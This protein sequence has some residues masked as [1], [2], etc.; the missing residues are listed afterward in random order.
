MQGQCISHWGCLLDYCVL[1]EIYFIQ[2][3]QIIDIVYDRVT[4]PFMKISEGSTITFD[5]YT[6]K[7]FWTFSKTSK[8][9]PFPMN[10]RVTQIDN[11]THRLT[12]FDVRLDNQGEYTCHGIDEES[13]HFTNEI[14]LLVNKRQ[15]LC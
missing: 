13:V 6:Q 12:I 8:R 2:I 15:Y 7:G 1:L 14:A 9:Y 5:C 10:T 4:P 11:T 3:F